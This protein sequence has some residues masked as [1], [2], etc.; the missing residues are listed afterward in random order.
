M[1]CLSRQID[2]FPYPLDRILENA[3]SLLRTG[4]IGS[5]ATKAQIAAAFVVERLD[6]LPRDRGVVE[7]WECLG[8]PGCRVAV[9]REASEARASTLDRGAGNQRFGQGRGITAGR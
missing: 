5:G 8:V 1:E 3:H 6:L 7:A 2:L 9:L 4:V